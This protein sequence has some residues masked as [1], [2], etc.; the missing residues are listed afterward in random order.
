[1]DWFV[2]VLVILAICALIAKMMEPWIAS[3]W[4]LEDEDLSEYEVNDSYKH[5]RDSLK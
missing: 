1:M 3:H 5:Y 4:N 2:V